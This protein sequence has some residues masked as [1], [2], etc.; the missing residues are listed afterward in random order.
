LSFG[1]TGVSYINI[2]DYDSLLGAARQQAE[3]QCLLFVF[4]KTSLPD[5]HAEDEKSRFHSGQGGALEAVMCV[6][7][8]P[9]QLGSFSDLERESRGMGQDGKIV[10]VSCLS[11]GKGVAPD[12]DAVE[13]SLNRM[14]E[15]VQRGGDLS[16]F[17]AF[18]RKGEPVRFH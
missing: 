2:T 15:T 8:T 1:T 7:K 3:P 4:L 16:K 12:S 11:G 17:M 6:D 18:D 9:D 13:L 5:D 14:V 10:L